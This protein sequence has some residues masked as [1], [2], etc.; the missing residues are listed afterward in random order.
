MVVTAGRRLS[1]HFLNKLVG[2]GSNGQLFQGDFIIISRTASCDNAL[3][4]LNLVSQLV[5]MLIGTF[6]VSEESMPLRICMIFSSKN[7]ANF[8]A[9][10]LW[11]VQS[12]K[13]G[14]ED[15]LHRFWQRQRVP[16]CYYLEFVCDDNFPWQIQA[17]FVVQAL[18]DVSIDLLSDVIYWFLV[19]SLSTSF[20]LF[21]RSQFI[22]VPGVLG[23]T[24]TSLFN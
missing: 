15:G 16:L 23:L 21:V 12:G 24:V 18:V 1:T 8:S 6:C 13:T 14:S 3:K 17:W 11:E 22:I 19:F 7:V 9:S 4:P 2:I 5:F 10:C 20:F